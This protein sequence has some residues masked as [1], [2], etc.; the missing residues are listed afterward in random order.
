MQNTNI[1]SPSVVA[2]WACSHCTTKNPSNEYYCSACNNIRPRSS[3]K[4]KRV[5]K[6]DQFVL[7]RQKQFKNPKRK[8]KLI[9]QQVT[10]KEV[11]KKKQ[12]SSAKKESKT[13]DLGVKQNRCER[14]GQDC[15]KAKG[16]VG[17]HSHKKMQVQKKRS[18]F[19]F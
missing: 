9:L 11:K 13:K 17:F 8:R 14:V 5:D 2:E 1:A 12:N 4:K 18:Y 10:K 16:E 19:F 7:N 15:P 6:V 3:R